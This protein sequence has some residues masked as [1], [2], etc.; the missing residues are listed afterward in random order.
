[1]ATNLAKDFSSGDF[2]PTPSPPTEKA[3]RQGRDTEVVRARTSRED[4]L[5]Q[6]TKSKDGGDRDSQRE[7]HNRDHDEGQHPKSRQHV[8]HHR[9]WGRDSKL[10]PHARLA[11]PKTTTMRCTRLQ[12]LEGPRRRLSEPSYARFRTARP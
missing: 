5:Y 2:F 12:G 9:R 11:K 1:M 4:V 3:H 7:D 6:P 8:Q 10:R